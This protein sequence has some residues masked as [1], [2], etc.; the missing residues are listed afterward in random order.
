MVGLLGVTPVGVAAGIGLTGFVPGAILTH[1][2][3]RD[4]RLAFPLGAL[5]LAVAALLAQL[6]A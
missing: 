6:D 2:K 4:L 5:G 1:L 3:A